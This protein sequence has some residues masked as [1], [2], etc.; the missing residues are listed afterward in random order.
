MLDPGEE[1]TAPIFRRGHYHQGVGSRHL[2][3]TPDD[4]PEDEIV[5]TPQLPLRPTNGY[6]FNEIP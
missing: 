2:P 5:L 4:R 6:G 1:N 3:E